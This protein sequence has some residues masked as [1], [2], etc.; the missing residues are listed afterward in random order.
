MC[1]D[2]NST[3]CQKHCLTISRKADD[4]LS[5]QHESMD[6]TLKQHNRINRE[7]CQLYK[8]EESSRKNAGK[9]LFNC[10]QVISN[11]TLPKSQSWFV[12]CRFINNMMFCAEQLQVFT[13]VFYCLMTWKMFV[14]MLRS[15]IRITWAIYNIHPL[16][17]VLFS[18]DLAPCV[19]NYQQQIEIR[20]QISL[21][22][23]TLQPIQK[24]AETFINHRHQMREPSRWQCLRTLKPK[25]WRLP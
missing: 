20:Y 21:Q 8:N 15:A 3:S 16:A 11:K 9:I 25:A 24:P 17:P 18:L 22:Q 2:E 5:N 14:T 12:D 10:P 1:P 4:Q 6:H 7:N 23:R 19:I 13:N